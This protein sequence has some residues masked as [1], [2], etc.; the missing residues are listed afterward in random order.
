MYVRPIVTTQRVECGETALTGQLAR[1]I[2][3]S[4]S[5]IGTTRFSIL[6]I[7]CWRQSKL[8]YANVQTSN[9][10]HVKKTRAS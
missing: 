5:P 10:L 3:R 2:V 8:T 7:L 4:L 1:E 9:V 6:L